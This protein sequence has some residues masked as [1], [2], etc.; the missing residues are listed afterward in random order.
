MRIPWLRRCHGIAEMSL[1]FLQ[2]SPGSK[3]FLLN[4]MDAS[5]PP[6]PKELEEYMALTPEQLTATYDPISG[7]IIYDPVKCP[8]GHIY[9]KTSL[10]EF[11]DGHRK[12]KTPAFSPV[13]LYFGVQP[14]RLLTEMKF[15]MDEEKESYEEIF[16][17]VTSYRKWDLQ[18]QTSRAPMAVASIDNLGRVF[19]LLD[20]MKDT[21]DDLDIKPPQIVVLGM[22]SSGKSSV[23]ERLTMLPIFPA[24]EKLCTRLPIRI[25][26]RRSAVAKQ[27]R[28]ELM[29]TDTKPYKS[30]DEEKFCVVGGMNSLRDEMEKAINLER[31]KRPG[32]RGGFCMDHILNLYLEGPDLPNLDL[33]DLP[34]LVSCKLKGDPEN[35]VEMSK[36]LIKREI[37]REHERSIYLTVVEASIADMAAAG[38]IFNLIDEFKKKVI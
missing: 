17:I 18:H 5:A 36:A 7:G 9:D 30:V 26:L 29:N 4:M 13:D 11:I 22:Q 37:L 23:L 28:L 15:L 20:Q 27:P 31:E 3:P 6:M 34:G 10:S 14:P 24:D 38:S 35:V 32:I 21:L 33:I 2:Y 1:L 12:N 8:D 16:R 19:D 25:Y